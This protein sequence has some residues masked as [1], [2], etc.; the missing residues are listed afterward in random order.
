[1]HPRFVGAALAAIADSP[2]A[3]AAARPDHRGMRVRAA[4]CPGRCALPEG[5]AAARGPRRRR[6]RRPCKRRPRAPGGLPLSVVALNAVS[7]MNDLLLQVA[8]LRVEF[9]A[10][11]ALC[12]VT[13]DLFAGE[14]LGLVGESGSGKSTLAGAILRLVRPCKGTVVWRGQDL[15][16]CESAVLRGLRHDMQ[17]VF[18]DPLAS[19]DPRMTVGESIAE[20]LRIFEPGLD[21]GARRVRVG[22][23]LQRVG[24]TSEMIG[25]Y[26]HELSGGQC[27][28]I[29]IAR[30]MI[31][32]P[33]LLICDEP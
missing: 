18:Q 5:A 23:M 13:F 19:L 14:T 7:S 16:S 9:D 26:P 28:R 33:N 4:L 12:D 10:R 8:G 1:M 2:R 29:G 22:G 6:R 31:L 30:A 15:L 32:G 17:I 24:L 11:V 25:R 3:P 21:A 27:Q 20:P